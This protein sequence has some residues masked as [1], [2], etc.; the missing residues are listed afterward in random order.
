MYTLKIANNF[1]IIIVFILSTHSCTKQQDNIFDSDEDDA[2]NVCIYLDGNELKYN[3]E[4]PI[5]GFQFNHN[6]CVTSAS[7]GDASSSGF[8][9]SS[10]ESAVLAFSFT[11][12]TISL[13]SGTLVILEGDV[14]LGCLSDFV[15]ADSEGIPFAQY[16]SNCNSF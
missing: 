14:T 7:G 10:S 8:T 16:I 2:N 4:I 11:G 9:I 15:F 5:A 1:I 13:G 6:G 12:S 3:T